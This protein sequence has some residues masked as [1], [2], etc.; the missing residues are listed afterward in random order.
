[1]S[2]VVVISISFTFKMKILAAKININ[3]EIIGI[4]VV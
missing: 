3:S 1:V 4:F 2:F